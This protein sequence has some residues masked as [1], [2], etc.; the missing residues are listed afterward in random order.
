MRGLK[1]MLLREQTYLEKIVEKAK[2]GLSATPE[3]HLSELIVPDTNGTKGTSI[4]SMYRSCRLTPVVN[5]HYSYCKEALL[6]LDGGKT[7]ERIKV[8]Q[9]AM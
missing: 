1:Q 6:Y 9:N 2:A 4:F 7:D 8:Y 5:L 3:G